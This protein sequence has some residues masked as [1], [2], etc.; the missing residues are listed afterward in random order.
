MGRFASV[1]PAFFGAFYRAFAESG[2]AGLVHVFCDSD[3][4]LWAATKFP[5]FCYIFYL[6]KFYEVLDTV[7]ILAKGKKVGM[8]QS[9]HHTGAIYT[10]YAGY[11]TSE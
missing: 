3:L 6:S 10:M 8:L 1:A 4:A 2:T 11:R 5:F 9:Y 7:I